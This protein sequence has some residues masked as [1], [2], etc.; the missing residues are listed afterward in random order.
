MRTAGAL[1]AV[2]AALAASGCGLGAGESSI[3]TGASITVTRDFGTRPVG[4]QR[5]GKLAES[6]TVMRVL[7]RS[8]DVRTRYGG[9]FVQ[10][11]DGIAGGR[12]DGRPVDWFFWVNGV[13]SDEG[14]TAVRLRHGDR[15]WWD[16]HD[17]GLIDVIPAV[18]G[19]FP[20]PFRAGIDGRRVPTRLECADG[21]EQACDE[22]A[23]RLD[24]IGVPPARSRPGVSAGG[25][26]LRV[27]VGEWKAIRGLTTV[28]LLERGPG[29]TGVFA[30][31]ASGG[32]SIEALDPAGG[33]ALRLGAGAG[34]VA[35][36]SLESQYPTWIVTGTDAAGTLAAAAALEEGALAQH[37]A[38]AI[39]ESGQAVSLPVVGR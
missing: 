36:T 7:Q 2:V 22:V 11:I 33:V 14:A 9:G 29:R 27:V 13:L 30:R 21:S 18:V 34:L 25:K 32:G 5:A 10:S 1:I 12:R 38:L 3:G 17:W 23:R 4:E 19:S 20:E 15:V 24:A 37:Y 28:G 39:D 35:A 6:D 31:P 8:F 16:H 26:L